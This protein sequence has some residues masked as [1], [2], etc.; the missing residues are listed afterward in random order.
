MKTIQ[1][2]FVTIA[3][4]L[5]ISACNVQTPETVQEPEQ[6]AIVGTDRFIASLS[7]TT[8]L[9]TK[10]G[11]IT[12][13]EARAMIEPIMILSKAYLEA[14]QYDFNEDFDDADDPRIAWV[15]LALAEYDNLY[16]IAT[17]TSVGGCVLQAIGVAGLLEKGGKKLVKALAKQALK[18]AVPYVGAALLVGDF[19]W[20][21]LD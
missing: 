10:S 1:F 12:E 19:V 18:K 11:E 3:S 8:H 16:G 7:S 2:L 4:A 13:E 9:L 5:L 17:K 14:N 21:M 6:V 20:C 15:A